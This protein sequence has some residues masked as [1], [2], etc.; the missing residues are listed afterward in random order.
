MG[1]YKYL[2][3]LIFYILVNF[4]TKG[5]ESLPNNIKQYLLTGEY[6][7]ALPLLKNLANQGNSQAQFQLAL[8]YLK[9]KTN[10][11]SLKQ[12]EQWL[13]KAAKKNNKACYLLGL[14]YF[15]NKFEDTDRS[16]AKKYLVMAQLNGN[17]K[18]KKLLAKLPLQNQSIELIN[19]QQ[20]LK[21][22]KSIKQGD[23]LNVKKL[24]QLGVKLNVQN[25]SGETPLIVAIKNK[26]YDIA[27][28]LLTLSNKNLLTKDLVNINAQDNNGNTA[29]HIAAMNN[30]FKI[31]HLLFYNKAGINIQNKKGQTPLISAIVA[32][33]KVAAQQLINEN[34]N[35]KIKDKLRKTAIFYAKKYALSLVFPIKDKKQKKA[36]LS[37]KSLAKKLKRIILQAKDPDSPYFESPVLAIAVAQKQ[38]K[39]LP[40]ILK[41]GYTPWQ[42]D[43][44]H[45]NAVITAIIMK[46]TNLVLTL[47]SYPIQKSLPESEY[48]SAFKAAIKYDQ[49]AVISKLFEITDLEKIKKWP[50]EQTPLWYAI[51]YKRFNAA[52]TIMRKLPPD[53]RQS[54]H[55]SSYLLFAMQSNLIEISKLLITFKVNLNLQDNK[56]RTALWY[57]AN[58]KN[59]E[60]VNRLLYDH[61][62]TELADNQGTPPLIQ[63]VIKNCYRCAEELITFGA[64]IQK[65]THNGNNALMFASQGKIKILQLFLNDKRALNIKERNN[66]S[67][68]PLMLSV[69]NGCNECVQMLLDKGANPKRKSKQGEDSFD[70]SKNN[71]KILTL[72]NNI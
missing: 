47:L 56:G 51:K 57:A 5:A 31:N 8:Y 7:Q 28:Y 52:M 39:L 53:N 35:V 68:T 48:I 22:N 17:N 63:A 15:Q 33:N 50:I 10:K 55:K 29:L 30:Q 37:D 3:I 61:A 69:K 27:V 2:Y 9:D 23:L 49:L 59:S 40:Y 4:S 44:H 42:G 65:K 70:L 6:Q 62:D 26:Q 32:R 1:Q 64:N 43:K 60:M 58:F 71:I 14:M 25:F 19:S 21:L 54:S 34:S 12:A 72:L 38:N 11:A 41:S 24:Y 13:I 67:Y 46:D 36:P 66:N 16:K 45:K 18:A 20:Q